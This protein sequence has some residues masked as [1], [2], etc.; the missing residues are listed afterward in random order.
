MPP[1]LLN[2]WMNY[3]MAGSVAL[4]VHPSICVFH[5]PSENDAF[6]RMD[7]ILPAILRP[8]EVGLT[9]TALT[10]EITS[11]KYRNQNQTE[12]ERSC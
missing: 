11:S 8:P 3:V 7:T 9:E 6:R 1:P 4:S 10:L 5:A 12:Q 2:G